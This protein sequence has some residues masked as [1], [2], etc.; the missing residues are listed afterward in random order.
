VTPDDTTP[1][2]KKISGALA[3]GMHLAVVVLF[4][5]GVSWQQRPLDGAVVVELW[6]TPL[7]PVATKPAP[8]PEVKPK[9]APKPEVKP[10]PKPEPTPKAE[11][12]PKPKPE[13][14]PPKVEP[15]PPPKP[16]IALREQLEKERLAKAEEAERR[17]QQALERARLEEE[18]R[19]LKEQQALEMQRRLEEEQRR[20]AELKEKQVLEELQRKLAL[21]KQEA[22]A[23]LAREQAAAQRALHEKYVQLIQH[24][25]R[26]Q[27]IEPPNLTGNPQVEFEVVLIPGGEVLTLKMR[28]SSGV[29]AYDAAVERAIIKA[30]PLPLPADPAL[31]QQ[32]RELHLRIRPKE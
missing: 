16:D 32:F 11:P 7:Q 28:R 31:F 14:P 26:R 24:H 9:P 18:E 6:N 15:K 4:V 5:V 1:R 2:E 17:K 20:L 22:A 12:K 25:V 19:K 13:P 30:S 29:P 10:K 27:I 3:L 8:K 21:E 23:R